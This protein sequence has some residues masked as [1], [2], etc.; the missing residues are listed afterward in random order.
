MSS[1]PTQ[2]GSKHMFEIEDQA[3]LRRRWHFGEAQGVFETHTGAILDNEEAM[4]IPAKFYLVA[5][6]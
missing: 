6:L 3:N 2:T 1:T 5:M 4:I